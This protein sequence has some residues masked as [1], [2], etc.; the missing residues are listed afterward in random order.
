[1][2]FLRRMLGVRDG[3]PSD[4]GV[5]EQRDGQGQRD[6]EPEPPGADDDQLPADE[7]ER[8]RAVLRADAERLDDDLLQRQLRYADRSWTPAPQGGERRADDGSRED[9]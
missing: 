7:L 5:G 3:Q 9:G 8:E 6:S 1:M 4:A 2:G